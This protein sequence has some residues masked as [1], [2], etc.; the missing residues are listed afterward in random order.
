M[1]CASFLC[2]VVLLACGREQDGPSAD[3]TDPSGSPETPSGPRT[4]PGDSDG[5]AF[6]R[7]PRPALLPELEESKASGQLDP[8]RPGL[9]FDP[10]CYL[11][12]QPNMAY[13][14]KQYVEAPSGKITVRTNSYGMRE[15]VDPGGEAA[16]LCVLVAG[17]SHTEGAVDNHQ[18]FANVLE[19]RLAAARPDQTVA[20]WNAG[21]AYCSF[22]SYLGTLYKYLP[23]EPDV[24]VMAVYTGNDFAAMYELGA[25]LLGGEMQVPEN[26]YWERLQQAGEIAIGDLSGAQAVSQAW[27]QLWHYASY[28]ERVETTLRSA[29]DYTREAARLC[30]EAGIRLVVVGIPTASEVEPVRFAELRDALDDHFDL[31]EV[32]RERNT[33]VRERYGAALEAEGITWFDATETLRA[34]SAQGVEPLYWIDDQHLAI[35]GHRALAE[36]LHAYV[37]P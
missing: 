27:N 2:L 13:E 15:D 22:P 35:E 6:L 9:V 5:A 17:D 33:D 16:D 12:R 32:E 4:A 25:R 37:S 36:A 3:P 14:M 31:D 30:D 18:S 19:A 23:L 7:P 21:V 10:L 20:V 24:F 29:V 8:K 1:R 11:A 26:A 34:E 28:P